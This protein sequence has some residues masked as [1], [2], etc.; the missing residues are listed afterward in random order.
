MR[1]LLLALAI[2][3]AGLL[4]PGGAH[5]YRREHVEDRPDAP[6]LFWESPRVSFR[7]AAGEPA[8]LSR[9]ELEDA[10][11]GSLAAWSLAGGCSRIELLDGG[12]AWG[13]LTNLDGGAPDG[14]NRV[15]ARVASWPAEIGPETLA[16]TSYA[17]DRASGAFL[18]ADIDLNAVDFRFSTA[19]PPLPGHDDLAN[20]LT[21]ELGHALGLAHSDDPRATLF[22]SAPLGETSKREL[23]DDDVEALCAIYPNG[24]PRARAGS[25][26]ARPPSRRPALA[27]AASALAI[28]ISARGRR[29]ARARAARRGD[30]S[31][32]TACGASRPRA[33]RG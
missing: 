13:L 10:F 32:G 17:Y 4:A 12:E 18:D 23:G 1:P 15:V 33:P 16:L 6:P 5:A 29:R 30:P 26:S 14:E 31:A 25:C 27:L 22:G 2:V 28:G 24:V 11:R 8:G 21:H 9:A 20:T 3:L 19:T 7:L